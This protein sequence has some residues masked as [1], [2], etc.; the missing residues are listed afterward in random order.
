MS[1]RP[2]LHSPPS[3]PS[4]S[5]RP[6]SRKQQSPHYDLARPPLTACSASGVQPA[7]A[8][9]AAKSPT[10]KRLARGK[11]NEI[12]PPKEESEEE[13]EAPAL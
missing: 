9:A 10:K 13:E 1:A 4:H 6:S 3:S 7:Q 2:R 5:S 11:G 12:P 8:K